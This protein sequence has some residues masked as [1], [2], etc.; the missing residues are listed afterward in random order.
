MYKFFGSLPSE[1]VCL[2]HPPL[3][4]RLYVVNQI[5]IHCLVQLDLEINVVQIV[6]K[7]L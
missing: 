2:F 3:D 1:S 6:F 7:F 5:F 4:V